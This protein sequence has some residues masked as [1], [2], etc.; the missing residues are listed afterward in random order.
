MSGKTAYTS[1]KESIIQLEKEKAVKEQILRDEFKTTL[2]NLHPVNLIKN[3]FTAITESP[4]VKSSLI[5]IAIPIITGMLSKKSAAANRNGS[6]LHKAGI[7][8]LD[9]LNRYL[10]ENPEVVQSALQSVMKY[11]KQKKSA[12]EINVEE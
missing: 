3:S 6:F 5:G 11:F 9:G 2:E 1:L 10:T 8:L 12:K 7:L 4:V